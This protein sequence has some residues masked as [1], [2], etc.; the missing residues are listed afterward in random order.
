MDDSAESDGALKFTNA[1]TSEKLAPLSRTNGIIQDPGR[2]FLFRE[3]SPGGYK[4]TVEAFGTNRCERTGNSSCGGSP[5]R[6]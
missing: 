5:G 6:T 3:P 4:C 2:L 1:W